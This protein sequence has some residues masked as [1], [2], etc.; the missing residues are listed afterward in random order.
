MT[1]IMVYVMHMI[2]CEIRVCVGYWL[3]IATGTHK[4]HVFVCG[5][6]CMMALVM[7][8]M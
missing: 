1:L 4:R 2:L 5:D 7:E 3:C 8:S 6:C